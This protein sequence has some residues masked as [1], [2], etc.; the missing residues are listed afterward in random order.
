MFAG[1]CHQTAWVALA[2][3]ASHWISIWVC[4]DA[5]LQVTLTVPVPRG[6]V[7]GEMGHDHETVPSMPTALGISC[8]SVLALPDGCTYWMEQVTPGME[9]AVN[10]TVSPR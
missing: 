3:I 2:R 9:R 5:P 6:L 10:V 7:P 4:E 1:E 8:G